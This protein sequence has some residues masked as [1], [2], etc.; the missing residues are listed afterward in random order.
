[1]MSEQPA[2]SLAVTV[3]CGSRPG[4]TDYRDLARA[5]G[6]AMAARGITLIFGAGTAGL[7]GALCDGVID[8]GGEAIGVQPGFMQA[9]GWAN[10]RCTRLI[11]T[12]DM[13]VRK[14]WMEEHADAFIILPGGIGTLDELITVMTTRQLEQHAKPIM[15]LDPDDYY[16]PFMDLLSHMIVHGFLD[17]AI[18]QMP[19]RHATPDAALTA[20]TEALATPS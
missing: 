7:M 10:Q 16:A 6:A 1:M 12:P 9:N 4:V 20:I 17:A 8:G 2:N 19:V 14:A 13:H 11:I 15:L 3:F 18:T 5:L